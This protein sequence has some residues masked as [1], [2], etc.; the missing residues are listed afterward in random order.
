[1][2]KET[3]LGSNQTYVNCGCNPRVV[4]WW[5]EQNWR[6]C[7]WTFGPMRKSF[8]G[9]FFDRWC[10]DFGENQE[11][12]L[13]FVLEKVLEFDGLGK[14]FVRSW[15]WKRWSDS[16]VDFRSVVWASWFVLRQEHLEC[17]GRVLWARNELD[18]KRYFVAVGNLRVHL[19]V[20]TTVVHVKVDRRKIGLYNNITYKEFLFLHLVTWDA[21][22]QVTLQICFHMLVIVNANSILFEAT[23]WWNSFGLNLRI[24]A[25]ILH[26]IIYVI[27]SIIFTILYNLF[28]CTHHYLWTM[29]MRNGHLVP[30]TL[31]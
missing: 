4:F 1:M 15:W 24:R 9:L 18:G 6:A 16:E 3:G 12:D 30:Y 7:P 14:K 2:T 17:F 29:Y 25:H 31:L 28:N 21:G 11:S 23:A 19:E 8:H 27:L 22:E 13:N 20:S 10:V 26:A 5:E